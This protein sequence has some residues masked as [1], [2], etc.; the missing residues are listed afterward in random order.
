[1]NVLHTTLKDLKP[2]EEIL[3]SRK[4]FHEIQQRLVEFRNMN[5]SEKFNTYPESGLQIIKRMR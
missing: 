1:M 4:T 3:C 2:G 5:P